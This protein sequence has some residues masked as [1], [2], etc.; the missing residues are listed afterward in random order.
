MIRS[1]PSVFEG[2]T[3]SI[4]GRLLGG[5]LVGGGLVLGGGCDSVPAPDRDQRR[6]S[7]TSLQ[8]S[9]DSLHESD[10]AP[11]EIEDSLAQVEVDVSARAADPDGTVERVVF[12]FEP[13]SN[14]R[15][16]ISG[17]LSAVEPPVYGGTLAL[18]VPLVD[19]VYTVR[20]F[21][22][23]DDSLSGNQVTGQFRFVPTDT[24][25]A[26]GGGN[27]S[28]MQLHRRPDDS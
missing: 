24:S 4:L 22:V 8:V 1:N 21:A 27:A 11:E 23:D 5:V 20:V 28:R 25:G 19:E 15:R 3:L 2:P 10:L 17:T 12:V 13:S 26:G 9:P 14:P 7:V 6:P 18:S 16:T